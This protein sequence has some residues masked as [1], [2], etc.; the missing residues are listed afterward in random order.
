MRKVLLYVQCCILMFTASLNA[1]TYENDI[2]VISM[3]SPPTAMRLGKDYYPTVIA[4]NY[5][6]NPQTFDLLI[7]VY[8]GSQIFNVIVYEDT[9]HGLFLNPGQA[10]TFS[11]SIPFVTEEN[12]CYCFFSEAI[13]PFDEDTSNNEYSM[14]GGNPAFANIYFGNIDATP[15]N[16]GLGDTV[17]V[18]VY[19]ELIDTVNSIDVIAT[20]LGFDNRYIDQILSEDIGEV[21]IPTECANGGF[22]F[23][24]FSPPNIAGWSSQNCLFLFN[25]TPCP[26]FNLNVPTKIATYAVVTTTDSSVYRAKANCIGPGQTDLIGLQTGIQG[27][28]PYGNGHSD[29]N[30]LYHNEYFSPFYFCRA[31]IVPGS[32]SGVVSN[33]STNPVE[34]IQVSVYH[35]DISVTTNSN[36]EYTIP[37]LLPGIYTIE[38]SHEY[39][40]DSVVNDLT[41]Y[42]HLPTEY[43]ITLNEIG[44]IDGHVYAINTGE[45]IKDV[46]VEIAGTDFSTVTDSLGYFF[47]SDLDEGF[48][49]ILFSHDYYDSWQVD[50]FL[51]SA[52]ET[53]TVNDIRLSTGASVQGIIMTQDSLPIEGATVVLANPFMETT[54]DSMGYFS[55]IELTSGFK[56]L[57]V[58]HP[59]YQSYYL[60]NHYSDWHTTLNIL[61]E[62]KS[63]ADVGIL[64]I[65]APQWKIQKDLP[66]YPLVYLENYGLTNGPVEIYFQ[67][68]IN[69]SSEIVYSDTI[70]GFY[71]ESGRKAMAEFSNPFIPPFDTT[72]SVTFSLSTPGD[73]NP[74][75]N[76]ASRQVTSSP[77][78]AIWYGNP[79]GSPIYGYKNQPVAMDIYAQTYTTHEIE[80][81]YA[82]FSVSEECFDSVITSMTINHV[83]DIWHQHTLLP[84]YTPYTPIGCMDITYSSSY[85]FV[86]NGFLAP[87]PVKIA[88]IFLQ[89]NTNAPYGVELRCCRA[90]HYNSTQVSYNYNFTEHYSPIIYL[91]GCDYKP[92]DINGDMRVVGADVSYLVNYFRGAGEPPVDSC[93]N[94]HTSEY[95]YSAADANGDC[96][97]IGSDITY[98]VNY[99]R[100]LQEEILYCPQTPPQIH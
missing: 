39:Y 95:V 77:A 62:E 22:S 98:L 13:S 44:A 82:L 24:E 42:E 68:M 73:V 8:E 78:V 46:S 71:I 10:D 6:S 32:I 21:Y 87:E 40:I 53:N 64:R 59:Q 74:E 69:S 25:L 67:A 30:I 48:Y 11:S 90:S 14:H 17:F 63:Q 3:T 27:P 38:F 1:Q 57:S 80:A 31:P 12:I 41:V 15:I 43:D 5:G 75:N 29:D 9:L 66:Y 19:V 83:Q 36:G 33:Q 26:I 61:L 76:I 45:P 50:S 70:S 91:E 28:N 60:H 18:D 88:T 37:D 2:A 97:V 7:K 55:F 96:T 94:Y 49:Q 79:D 72:Y 84:Y 20:I 54:T 81:I 4:M 23:Q 89:A 47:I 85:D 92:G 56:N 35:N 86:P 93:F 58:F 51:V 34:G 100:G 16:V 65:G 99:F 52:G